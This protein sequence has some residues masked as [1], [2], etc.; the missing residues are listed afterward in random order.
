MRHIFTV[1]VMFLLVGCFDYSVDY[2]DE[3]N[4]DASE[5]S[6]NKNVSI[7][8]Q[9]FGTNGNFTRY[10]VGERSPEEFPNIS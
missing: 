8:L 4:Y 9:Y 2:N 7:Y 10:D 3:N 5:I 6:V 1:T